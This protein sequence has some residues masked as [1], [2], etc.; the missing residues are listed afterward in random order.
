MHG[1]MHD[2]VDDRVHGIMHGV[3]HGIMH[4]FSVKQC[5][6]AQQQRK[7]R[8]KF[9]RM[10]FTVPSSEPL[11]PMIPYMR[12]NGI[13]V[14]QRIGDNYVRI[15]DMPEWRR[16][17]YAKQECAQNVNVFRHYE[18]GSAFPSSNDCYTRSR[19]P[20]T[21]HIPRPTYL[22]Y[23]NGCPTFSMCWCVSQASGVRID[24]D[25]PNMCKYSPT[26][27]V[28]T[29]TYTVVDETKTFYFGHHKYDMCTTHPWYEKYI[30]PHY[31]AFNWLH[32]EMAK[33]GLVVQEW[34]V[35]HYVVGP[36]D[37]GSFSERDVD[38][39][40]RLLEEMTSP[41][42]LGP[43][44]PPQEWIT[45]DEA[46]CVIETRCR[47]A[48]EVIKLRRWFDN[49]P[50][51]VL[52]GLGLDADFEGFSRIVFTLPNMPKLFKEQ[53]IHIYTVL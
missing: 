19:S 32:E 31:A 14:S 36:F 44:T 22:D 3:M 27:P 24:H 25:N 2:R 42:F 6:F 15:P 4:F 28:C 43:D 41:D 1:R 29:C 48:Y 35:G 9:E 12:I 20:H 47:Q 45:E 23:D 21:D 11:H 26:Y 51:S 13:D 37:D 34:K 38:E 16:A 7:P 10:S 18:V 30:V 8:T 40:E 50:P 33:L 49:V 53:G 5:T 46:M 52:C 39:M 17:M